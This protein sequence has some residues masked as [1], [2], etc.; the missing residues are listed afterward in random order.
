MASNGRLERSGRTGYFL[1]LFS[2]LASDEL[3]FKLSSKLGAIPQAS[4]FRADGF[5]GDCF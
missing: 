2:K 5:Y 4:S 1:S 3:V